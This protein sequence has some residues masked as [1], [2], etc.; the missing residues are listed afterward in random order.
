MPGASS[1]NLNRDSWKYP[2]Q[3]SKSEMLTAW[4]GAALFDRPEAASKL[5]VWPVV[6]S[7]YV[8]LSTFG[9]A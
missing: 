6:P 2:I 8:M 7:E 5:F 4:V 3:E 9:G 1:T